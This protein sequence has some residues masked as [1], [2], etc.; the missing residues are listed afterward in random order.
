MVVNS[1]LIFAS[2]LYARAGYAIDRPTS[3]KGKTTTHR[4]VPAETAE[5][6]FHKEAHH[7]ILF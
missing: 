4:T 3:R 1:A 7:P 5:T 6:T 2:L